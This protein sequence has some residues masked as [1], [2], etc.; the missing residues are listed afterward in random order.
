[1]NL[2]RLLFERID[3]RILVGTV[4]FLAIMVLVGWVA[5]NEGA[6]MTAFEQQYLARSIERGAA[7]F[8]SNC[9]PC[10]ATDGR[11]NLG[12][13]PAL[14]SPYLFGHN[15]LAEVDAQIEALEIERGVAGTNGDTTRVGEIDTELLSLQAERDGL[16]AEM[17]PAIALGFNPDEYSRLSS[18]G[19]GSTLNDFVFST[20]YSGRPVSE[21]YWPQ[22]MVAWAAETGGSLRTDQLQDITNFILNWGRGDDWTIEDLNAVRQ[23]PIYPVQPTGGDTSGEP[24]IGA[25]TELAVIMENLDPLTGDPQ[26]G[27]TLYNSAT[28][29][30][31]G[32]H[33]AGAGVAPPV[34]GTWTRVQEERLADPL[35]ADYTG[36]AYLA[37]SIIH[38]NAFAAPG[39]WSGIMPENF[40]DRMTYQQLADIIAYLQT[41]DQ[42]IE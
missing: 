18:L 40:G 15:F 39:N 23:F 32:C 19:W 24:V 6:R 20:L 12:R 11:G 34:E 2:Q 21:S 31:F 13:A 33:G 27:Q 10:H 8:A 26:N 14:N 5:I 7:L 9:S 41:Q 1:M 30:C 37:E 38:P 3:H 28:Y 42:P 22:P 36:E 25:D 4:S 17:A 29:A 16:I 35:F